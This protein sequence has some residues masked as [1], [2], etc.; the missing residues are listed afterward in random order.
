MK[1]S[2]VVDNLIYVLISSFVVVG[3]IYIRARILDCLTRQ[4][5]TKTRPI[6]PS[7]TEP[8]PK[9]IQKEVPVDATEVSHTDIESSVATDIEQ[10]NIPNTKNKCTLTVFC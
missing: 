1:S 9:Y 3:V 10:Y 6:A 2:R 5:N 4:R 7:P 8:K